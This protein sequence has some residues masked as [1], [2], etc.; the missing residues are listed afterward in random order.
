MSV[1]NLKHILLLLTLNA[2]LKFILSSEDWKRIDPCFSKKKIKTQ[3]QK[4]SKQNYRTMNA[5]IADLVKHLFI[6]LASNGRD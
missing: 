1:K 5:Q 3:G 4:I 6:I 2:K